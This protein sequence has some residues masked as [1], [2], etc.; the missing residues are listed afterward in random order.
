M[1]ILRTIECNVPGCVETAVETK[2]NA[3]WPGWGAVLGKRD[4]ETGETDFHLC[5]I[6]L[7]E[8]FEFLEVR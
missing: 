8:V 3:G 2:P 1:S 4:D 6:H 7:K 5:P